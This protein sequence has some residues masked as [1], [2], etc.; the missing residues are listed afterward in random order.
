MKAL[1]FY[2]RVL[3]SLKRTNK[4]GKYH[5]KCLKELLNIYVWAKGLKSIT[6]TILE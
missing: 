3:V 5:I 1:Y 4:N 2:I 6:R